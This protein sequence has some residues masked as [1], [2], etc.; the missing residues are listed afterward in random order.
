MIG[1]GTFA[2]DS[3]G[4]LLFAQPT[5]RAIEGSAR[6]QKGIDYIFIGEAGAAITWIE[7]DTCSNYS[8]CSG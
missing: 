4:D 1:D 6:R 8:H 5:S 3:L 2:A 7:T